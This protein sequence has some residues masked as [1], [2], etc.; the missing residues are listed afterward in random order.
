[1]SATYQNYIDGLW[2]DASN[3]ATFENR[4]PANWL[5][6][7]GT[8]PLSTAEDA[9]RAAEAAHA[10]YESW[11]LMPAPHRGDICRRAGDIMLRRKDEIARIMTHEMGKTLTETRGDVQEGID[12][13]FYCATEGRRLFG[14]NTPSELPNKL[15]L[16]FRVPIGVCGLITPWNF[17]MAIPTWNIFPGLVAG[18]TFVFKPAEDTPHTANILVEILIEAGLP[19]G[20]LNLVHGEGEVVGA[21][22]TRHPLIKAVSFTGSTKTGALVAERCGKHTKHVCLEMGGKNA[23]IVMDDADIDLS[24]DGVLWGAFGTTG[25][26]CTATSRLILHERIHDAFIEKLTARASALV[27]GDGMESNVNV[28]PLINPKQLETIERYVAIGKVEGATCILGGEGYV[29]ES[30]QNGWFYKPTIFTN[31]TPEMTI[32]REEIFGPVLSVL[33]VS[34]LDEALAV[35]NNV[36]YGLSS[37]IYTRNINQAM[38]AMRDIEAGIIY[39]NAPT[40]GAEAH[41][42]FG[43]MKATGN[44][45]REGGWT[46]FDFYT[47]WKVVYID[48]S[49][50]L[51]R[52]QI[53]VE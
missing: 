9:E 18:N 15:N 41:M 36:A 49:G 20:V 27:I 24:V 6:V 35:T 26:R 33:K 39:I 2:C 40:I 28:G 5:D 48:Y 8:F 50:G 38:M 3:G 43:G 11:R 12:T 47:Q 37:S 30:T 7:I 25:Q 21:A 16:S 22:I 34:S 46:V 31:V 14:I 44:G 51:Q 53:D 4:N 1:M 42:P 10:A 52:A 17:P 19:K 23:Q 13:A 45:H 29:N 32:A